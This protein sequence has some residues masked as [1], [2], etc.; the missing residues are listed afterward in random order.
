MSI[1]NN[2]SNKCLVTRLNAAVDNDSLLKLGEARFKIKSL[3]ASNPGLAISIAAGEN[4]VVI[5]TDKAVTLNGV[6][7][8]T[9]TISDTSHK[10]FILPVVNEE[11]TFSISDKSRLSYFVV[12][13]DKAEM[14]DIN[15]SYLTGLAY[16]TI[17]YNGE[18]LFDLSVLEQS[19]L[20]QNVI[21]RMNA[22]DFGNV[23]KNIF[24]GTIQK[25]VNV[26]NSNMAGILPKFDNNLMSTLRLDNC[27]NIYGAFEDVVDGHYLAYA[28]LSGVPG[29]TVDASSVKL[30]L[31]GRIQFNNIQWSSS[32][33]RTE[34][35]VMQGCGFKTSTDVDNM[36]INQ[37]RNVS[38]APS[39]NIISYSGVERTSASDTAIA[40][41]KAAGVRIIQN[42]QD[43]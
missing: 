37:A 4:P 21:L 14:V 3:D 36:L 31:M 11:Y 17:N 20:T 12:E 19:P 42:G 39:G 6:T 29:I 26:I 34:W 40:T 33:S 5:T 13:N 10:N 24:K 25:T 38:K 16:T 30:N 43:Q 22:K 35:L 8:T 27:P 9:F 23:P 7:A 18:G 1:I 41:L 2:M 15:A 28:I 32:T